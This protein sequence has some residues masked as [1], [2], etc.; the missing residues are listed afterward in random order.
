MSH[1]PSYNPG[2]GST[3]ALPVS[4][5][6]FTGSGQLTVNPNS[7]GTF[8]FF[9]GSGVSVTG[10]ASTNSLTFT[11][12]GVP[13]S[14]ANMG[15]GATSFGLST[16]SLIYYD[17]INNKLSRVTTGSS[18]QTLVSQGAGLA[19]AFQ[20]I[21]SGGTVN[22]TDNF[23]NSVSS[24]VYK[25]LGSTAAGFPL[26]TQ[27][28]G[29]SLFINMTLIPATY[30]G[31]GLA[32]LT[33]FGVLV[34]EGV[35]NVHATAAGSSGQVLLGS[36]G[37]PAFGTI[38]S[39]A[40][41]L[42]I[43]AA[44]GEINVDF[45]MFLSVPLGG[46]GRTALT[47]F[48]VLVGQNLNGVL[49][50]VPGTSGQ[51]LLGTTVDP[52]FGSLTSSSGTLSF[53]AGPGML[54]LEV[55]QNL[56][57]H[58]YTVPNGGT[59]QTVLTS[60]GV[61]LGHG[62][63]NIHATAAGTN[64]QVLIG[65]PT[66]PVFSSITSSAGTL[67]FTPG[68]GQLNVDIAVPFLPAFGGTGAT[69]F[70]AVTSS[71]L[72]YNG[73]QGGLLSVNAGSLNEVLVSQGTG[74]GP[75]FQSIGAPGTINIADNFGNSVSSS[76][77]TIEG[78]A[79]PNSP[80]TT[81]FTGNSLFINMPRLLVYY[82][83][84][85]QTTLTSF[86]VLIGA[87]PNIVHATAA[88]ANGQILMGTPTDPVFGRIT[89]SAGTLILTSGPGQ[90]NIDLPVI[91]SVPNRGTGNGSLTRYGVLIG[92]GAAGI[93]A[94]A[95]GTNGQLL[96]RTGGDP[97]FSS[98]TSSAG[99]L[100]LT[101]G[102][103][104]LNI[105]I[106]VP[107]PIALGGT[108][109]TSFG[110][111]TSSLTYYNQAQSGLT[112]I[113]S[114]STGQLLISQ[115][116]GRPPLF[117]TIGTNGINITD[118]FGTS[119]S[120]TIFTILGST[121]VGF[122]I[123]TQFT[124]NS[125]F[126]NMAVNSVSYGGTGQTALTAF[127]VLVGEGQG[128]IHA[129]TGTNGQLLIG[130]PT[131]P[132]FGSLTSSA[133]T[134]TFAAGPGTLN[135]EANVSIFGLFEP[136]NGGTGQTVL[137]TF[138]VL[139]GEGQGNVHAVTGTNG[140]LLIGS[141]ADPVFG[142]LTSSASTVA[143]TAGPGQLNVDLAIPLSTSFGGSGT[144]SFGTTAG[145]MI[146]YSQPLNKL[147]PVGTGNVGQFLL[148]Q[149]AGIPPQFQTFGTATAIK[150]T[151]NFGNSVNSAV[152]QILGSTA[153]GFPI[154]TQFVGTSLFIN[155]PLLTVPYGGTGQ[156]VLN[157]F[158]VLVGE[159]LGGI[160]ATA[161]GTNGQLLF[162]T[163][164]DP[165][166]GNLTS[167]AGTIAIGAGPGSLNLDLSSLVYF[168]VPSGGTGQ[169]VLTTFGV[170]IGN[171]SNKIHA[172]AAGTN[173]Q[174]LMGTATDPAFNYITSSAG[175]IILTAGPGE[176][177]ADFL[178]MLS[179]AF[180]GSNTTSFGLNTSSVIYYD[181]ADN[182]LASVS[183]GT[184]NQV[185]VSQG[186]GLSPQFLNIAAAPAINITDNFGNS[187]SSNVFKIIGSTAPGF[188]ITTQFTGNSL[189]I[190]M[191]VNSVPYG[192]TGQ[193]AL[194]NFGVLIGEGSGN[195]HATVA[196][197]NGQLLHRNADRSGIRLLKLLQR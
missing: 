130:S 184:L 193:T 22:I 65:T 67:A 47:S 85:G 197:T 35:G 140:Q 40:G 55:V 137:T 106:S 4:L 127:G 162:G 70:G 45:N 97:V 63:G 186:I 139:I 160:H 175:T 42:N 1:T 114:G 136:S 107:F 157:S 171:G 187:V 73:I 161:A 6:I 28:N 154:T 147:S 66:D 138:G 2:S 125:L 142:S 91:L 159:G 8:F 93:H 158:G 7:S 195:V 16:G 56:P 112:N 58:I 143:I 81:Q 10:S 49:A 173:G 17:G 62:S 25:I 76:I 166:F 153:P 115:G 124:G 172:T 72:Y 18:G 113:P 167:S 60:F 23:G 164:A 71:V 120:S 50:T 108:G 90:F 27:F 78:N 52:V 98:V 149:G 145:S 84:T 69:S 150:I 80:F 32:A 44:S 68:P 87:G 33:T 74:L 188:P 118:N 181:K 14:I 103:G 64:G 141:P 101:S 5:T 59:G 31:T 163:S 146:Y 54:N 95:P 109:A 12:P 156:T 196:G 79:L 51:L 152:F 177:N 110:I 191:P 36:P 116:I 39:S 117:Q 126:I 169:T 13:F 75:Q 11:G 53:V 111:T 180:G 174:V 24:A 151:D 86:G 155:M 41:T 119:V 105:D 179:I 57:S 134:L 102:P 3:S 26:T 34:G 15:T 88:G 92:E 82:G 123:T 104:Q 20:S 122:P 9:G 194:T 61:L 96:I 37:D 192:G 132:V 30:G 168:A 144:T 100:N 121:A 29:D 38:S 21:G 19:P 43:T 183:S 99:T 178:S 83:G 48:G 165:A 170:L 77:F 133:G 176:L 185:L 189:Y 182:I 135:L 190:D 46:L 94:T 148:S 131:D 128:N 89:S 129:V